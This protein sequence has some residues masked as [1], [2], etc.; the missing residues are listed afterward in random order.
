MKYSNYTNTDYLILN[1]YNSRNMLLD[2]LMQ[3][4]INKNYLQYWD[5]YSS[6][7]TWGTAC[8]QIQKL[9]EGENSLCYMAP[10]TVICRE[11]QKNAPA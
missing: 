8:P 7:E 10:G 11:A 6:E 1:F 4:T 3:M 5:I 2:Y 9:F